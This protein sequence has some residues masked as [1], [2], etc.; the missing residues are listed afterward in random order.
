VS[1]GTRVVVGATVLVVVLVVV[2]IVVVL[3]VAVL[4]GGAVVAETVVPEVAAV[5][6]PDAARLITSTSAAPVPH[7]AT[8]PHSTNHG[9]RPIA[10]T[11]HSLRREGGNPGCTENGAV[12][13]GPPVLDR[14]GPTLSRR[15]DPARP[16]DSR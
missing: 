7:A 5:V 16:L 8:T 14:A 4:V 13:L 3:V 6:V 9:R 10:P 11:L 1:A 12:P 2:L 15:P